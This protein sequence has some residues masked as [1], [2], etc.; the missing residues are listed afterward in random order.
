MHLLATDVV[1]ALRQ[2][3][4]PAADG[5]LV[6]WVSSLP[7][8][9]LFISV[10]TLME[11]ESVAARMERREKAHAAAIRGWTDAHLK[12]AFDGRILAVDE[13]VVARWG[14]LGYAD[15]RDGLLAA[16][17]LEHAMP[18]ATR[19]TAAFR[20]GRVKTVNPWVQAPE[21]DELDWREASHS[22]PQWLK[23]LFVRG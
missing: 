13:P 23:S 18:L 4:A 5:P 9:S 8:S 14:R 19:D 17:A 21:A 15:P 12:P 6:D 10:V 3:Q 22:A 20:H 1:W 2:A 7:P 11:L 16:T